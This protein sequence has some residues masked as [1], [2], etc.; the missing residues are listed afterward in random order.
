[1]RKD[2]TDWPDAKDGCFPIVAG[3]LI[4]LVAVLARIFA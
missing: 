4:V 1:M 3:V 2:E